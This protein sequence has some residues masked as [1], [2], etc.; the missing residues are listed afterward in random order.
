MFT[1]VIRELGTVEAIEASDAGARLRI[2]AALAEG[3]REGDSVAVEGACLT[4]ATVAPDAFEADVMNQTLGLTTLGGLE[5]GDRV[6]LEP[7]LRAAEP[8]GGHIVQGHVDGVGRLLSASEDGISRRLR[9]RVP[10]GL[11]RYLVEHGSVTVAGV[12]LTVA[13]LGGAELEVSLI[14]ETLERTTLGAA[15]E[16]DQLNLELDI[17]ARYV[18]RLLGFKERGS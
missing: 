10:D 7:A 17:I 2:R 9:V 11:E 6:N 8:L 3:L 12:S 18:E 4:A 5:A 1:G 16:G 15:G 14:P 13:G